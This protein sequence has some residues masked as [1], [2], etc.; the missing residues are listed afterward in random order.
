MNDEK[1]APSEIMLDTIVEKVE[2]QQKR[3][4]TQEEK[5]ALVEKKVNAIPDHSKDFEE[6]K[7]GVRDLKAVSN[8]QNA[9]M[10]K[11]QGFFTSLEIAVAL[12]RRPVKS[13]VH[14]DHHDHHVP[15]IIWI[16]AGLFLA[17]CLVCSGWYMTARDSGQ[18]QA[19]DIKYR[20]LKLDAD[21][22]FHQYLVRLD[23]IYLSDPDKMRKN[24]IEQ[25][26]LKQKRLELIDQ[27]QT[28]NSK[29]G[30]DVKTGQKKGKGK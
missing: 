8:G 11:L 13:H 26:R 5:L 14:H 22:A 19:N 25:E 12:L 29:I 27:L 16:A 30:P 15:K 6:V 1:Q 20:H 2:S 4:Q 7:T 9:I 28:V 10:E 21:S 17:L 23:S 24:V 18:Y 3:M